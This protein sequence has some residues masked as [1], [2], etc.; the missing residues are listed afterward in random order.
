MK[1]LTESAKMTEQQ[2]ILLA[3]EM[4]WNLVQNYGLVQNLISL[5][6]FR[7]FNFFITILLQTMKITVKCCKI[8]E[9]R[10]LLTEEAIERLCSISQGPLQVQILVF[11]GVGSN[12][13]YRKGRNICEQRS[14]NKRSKDCKR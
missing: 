3:G 8:K 7:K 4:L 10:L 1:T 11:N 2:L 5:C 12:S 14:T 13:L 6:I 9:K